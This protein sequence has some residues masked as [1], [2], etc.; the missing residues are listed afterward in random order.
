MTAAFAAMIAVSVAVTD[1]APVS[2][3]VFAVAATLLSFCKP[4][5]NL[6]LPTIFIIFALCG[7]TL[8]IT[9]SAIICA[10]CVVTSLVVKKNY[11]YSFPLLLAIA[12]IV[13]ITGLESRNPLSLPQL[14]LFFLLPC[15]ASIT[16]GN[17]IK[18]LC[19]ALAVSLPISFG[20]GKMAAIGL[21]LPAL[22][23]VLLYG[24]TG[25]QSK[26]EV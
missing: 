6:A 15:A 11:Y 18:G 5:R 26:R 10:C 7:I 13:S 25:I 8:P 23:P 22:I 19:T 12:L 14:G 16:P 20:G 17:R 1:A 3:V 21:L 9:V 24:N 4:R 2:A